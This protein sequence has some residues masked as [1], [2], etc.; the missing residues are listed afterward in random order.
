[1]NHNALLKLLVVV[2]AG[3]ATLM[4]VAIYGWLLH[5]VIDQA[6]S[7]GPVDSATLGAIGALGP[8]VGGAVTGMF[9]LLTS[10]S[11]AP[12]GPV[13]V[14]VQDEPVEVVDAE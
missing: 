1:M 12:P 7:R 4:L 6:E 14:T 10:T 11:S 13:P 5:D 8:L 9:A 3:T 2:F